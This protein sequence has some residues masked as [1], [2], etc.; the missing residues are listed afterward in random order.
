MTPRALFNRAFLS[1]RKEASSRCK[2]QRFELEYTFGHLLQINLKRLSD[3][4]NYVPGAK[5]VFEEA[6]MAWRSAKKPTQAL[7]FRTLTP[8]LELAYLL[9]A[10]QRLNLYWSPLV[11]CGQDED[12]AIGTLYARFIAAASKAVTVALKSRKAV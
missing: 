7:L 6:L 10:L 12:N 9:R 8:Y 11:T 2:K 5:E 1:A 4:L 3:E